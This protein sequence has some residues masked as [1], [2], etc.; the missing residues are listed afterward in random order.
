MIDLGCEVYDG[1]FEGVVGWEGD[2]EVEVVWVVDWV[3]GGLNV[4]VLG[5]DGLGW[6][7]GD[8]DVVWGWGGGFGKFLG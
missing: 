8:G 4:D 2:E 3:F 1:R 7:K 6:G 5:V